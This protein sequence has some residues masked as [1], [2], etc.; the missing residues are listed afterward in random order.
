MQGLTAVHPPSV[1]FSRQRNKGNDGTVTCDESINGPCTHAVAFPLHK[2]ISWL[3]FPIPIRPLNCSRSS[4]SACLKGGLAS[5]DLMAQ[6]K[7]HSFDYL[8]ACSLCD[9]LIHQP[10]W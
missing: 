6:A 8:A 2:V 9:W 5:L 3:L 7:T 10:W 1:Q 4:A